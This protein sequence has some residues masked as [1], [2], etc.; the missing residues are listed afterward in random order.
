AIPFDQ[1]LGRYRWYLDMQFM[2]SEGGMEVLGEPH[3]WRADTNWKQGAENFVGDSSHTFT[4]HQSA[5]RAG[6]V[7]NAAVAIPGRTVGL[8]VSECD[9]HA[10]AMRLS[11]G[12]NTVFW[13]YPDEVSRHFGTG[14]L[15]QDQYELAKRSLVHDGTVFPNFSFLHIGLTDSN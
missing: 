2:L 13:M 4:V 5:L 14:R 15:N 6:V 1:Y 9:G 12:D 10:V 3:R 7:G 8:H 11:N